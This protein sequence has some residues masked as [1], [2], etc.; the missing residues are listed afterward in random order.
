MTKQPPMLE[1]R[2][3]IALQPDAAVT[4]ADLAALIEETETYIAK[5]DESWTVDLPSSFDP[6]T[7]AGRELMR[8][9]PRTDYGYSCCQNCGRVSS[10]CTSKSKQ[11]DGRQRH[12]HW[13]QP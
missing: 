9:S 3:D 6:G 13:P 2:I 5:A 8:P 1:E 4:S 11:R 10:R 12:R 7:R